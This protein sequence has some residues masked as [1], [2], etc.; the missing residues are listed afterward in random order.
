MS[1]TSS[2]SCGATGDALAGGPGTEIER[3]ESSDSDM[4]PSGW[5]RMPPF[6]RVVWIG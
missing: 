3:G 6:A 2:L 4:K 1:I 5:N